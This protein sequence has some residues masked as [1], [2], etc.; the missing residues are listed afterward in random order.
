[1]RRRMWPGAGCAMPGHVRGLALCSLVGKGWLMGTAS[2][3]LMDLVSSLVPQ[4]QRDT[5]A[6]LLR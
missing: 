1:M 4:Y 3:L 2:E 6:G 5:A